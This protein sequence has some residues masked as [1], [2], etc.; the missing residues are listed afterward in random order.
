MASFDQE[1]ELRTRAEQKLWNRYQDRRKDDLKTVLSTEAGRRFI[2]T[3]FKLTNVRK[4]IWN[5]NGSEKDRLLGRRSVGC[6]IMDEIMSPKYAD[7]LYPLYQLLEKEDVADGVFM[8][9][10]I[11]KIVA[12]FIEKR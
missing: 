4:N 7:E 1:A 6:D 10:E 11:S 5:T 8:E 12:Q 2:A 3:L 9:S